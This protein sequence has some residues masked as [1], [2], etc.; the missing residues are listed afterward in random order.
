MPRAHADWKIPKYYEVGKLIG[1]GSYGQVCEACDTRCSKMVAIKRVHRVFDDLIDCKRILREMAILGRVAN[2]FLVKLHDIVV[3]ENLDRFNELYIVLEICDS[4]LKK[5]FRTPVFLTELHVKT[6]MYNI[7]VGTRYLH[8]A[9]IYHRDLKPANCLVNQDCTVKICDFGL[10]RAIG[11]PVLL[12]AGDLADT[13]RE[14]NADGTV[15]VVPHTESLKRAMTSHVVTRWYRAPELILLEENYTGQIDVWSVGCIFAECLGMLNSVVPRPQDRG[16]LFP[17]STCFPLSPDHKHAK[18]YK[19]H[20]RGNR[21]QLNVIFNI[22]GTPNK[23]DL[24]WL[25]KEDARRYIQCFQPREGSGLK[26][27]FEHAPPE[28]VDLLFRMLIFNANKRITIQESIDH[29]YFKDVRNSEVEKIAE[30]TV[31]LDFESDAELCEK[32]LRFYFLREVQRFHPEVVIP[33]NLQDAVKG[34]AGYS[35]RK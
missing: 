27:R 19:F 26:N 31:I 10:S 22:L 9:G 13:P 5:L 12:G 3:P 16:P 2:L 18:D 21:D 14:Q 1:H 20:T 6:L 8:S 34:T 24:A 30:Q 35:G 15:V 7:C 32:R 11:A 25:S 33:Q 17:G 23:D 28:A 29:E 4:D